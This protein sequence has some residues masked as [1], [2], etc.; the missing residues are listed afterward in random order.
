LTGAV[1]DVIAYSG[2]RT[3]TKED[4]KQVDDVTLTDIDSGDLFS[5]EGTAKDIE[6]TL[7]P[8]T[9]GLNYGFLVY[10]GGNAITLTPDGT[11]QF[12]EPVTGVVTTG[13]ASI[14][15]GQKHA[16]IWIEC[17]VGGIWTATEISGKWFNLNISKTVD[18]NVL[19]TYNGA[20]FNNSGDADA[21]VFTLPAAVVGLKYTFDVLAA[22]QMTLTPASG[23]QICNPL[24]GRVLAA[25][26]SLVNSGVIGS[27]IE[28]E[29]VEAGIWT[30][31]KA[32]GDW[33]NGIIAKTANFD[34]EAADS[35]KK[36]SNAGASGAITAALPAAIVGLKYT[37]YVQA[38]QE[39]QIAPDGAETIALPSTGAQS[40]AGK[41]IVADAIGENVEIEC[42]VAG[43]W[44]VNRYIGT[45]TA[46]A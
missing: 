18:Y 13:G 21:I 44:N 36:Y 32:V 34:I 45:W 12:I 14:S 2:S 38:A 26:E 28:I 6:V 46:Q 17:Q 11:E 22:Y 35:G 39:L 27:N 8:A 25:D 1:S 41:Y 30:V 9:V 16:Y 24:N 23:E 7:P 33:L 5:N 29:C 43:T 42:V 20:S 40:A 10:Q 37:M 19:A 31:R 3:A 15:S 4:R